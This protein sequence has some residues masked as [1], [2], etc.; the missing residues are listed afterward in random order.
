MQRRHPEAPKKPEK[1]NNKNRKK[2][3]TAQ[4]DA[5]GRVKKGLVPKTGF[6]PR[7]RSMWVV[8]TDK[9]YSLFSVVLRP[10]PKQAWRG[11][12]QKII[13]S[14]MLTSEKV[15]GDACVLVVSVCVRW[16]PVRS[17]GGEGVHTDVSSQIAQA[18]VFK[19]TSCRCHTH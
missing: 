14:L 10:F 11:K 15:V 9:I 5:R 8:C 6:D 18:L 13:H 12:D 17:R 2:T 7:N 1:S 3:K 16:S 19:K 4:G